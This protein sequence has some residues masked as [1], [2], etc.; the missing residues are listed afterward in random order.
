MNAFSVGLAAATAVTVDPAETPLVDNRADWVERLIR[1]RCGDMLSDEDFAL[2][3]E[4]MIVPREVADLIM[5]T[6]DLFE[7]KIAQLEARLDAER[8]NAQ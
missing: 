5:D 3:G 2:I 1:Q 8:G 7:D 6:L 4:T